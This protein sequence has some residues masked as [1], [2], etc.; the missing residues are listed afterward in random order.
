V[1]VLVPVVDKS[2]ASLEPRAT[3]LELDKLDRLFS[4]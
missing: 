3:S 1:T 2:A 4:G